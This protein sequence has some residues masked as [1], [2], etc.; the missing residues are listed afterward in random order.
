MAFRAYWRMHVGIR[1][2]PYTPFQSFVKKGGNFI[3]VCR[4]GINVAV[5]VGLVDVSYRMGDWWDNGIVCVR[6]TG[7]DMITAQFFANG[8]APVSQPVW[9]TKCG[10]G[11]KV[12]AS[13]SAGDFFVA[14]YC[15]HRD[16]Q[17][18]SR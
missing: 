8:Y 5:K 16:A 14:G 17:H 3:D 15:A 11:L 6:Y 1:E 18:D 13:P 10:A 12:S 7:S 9:F 4:D 2:T